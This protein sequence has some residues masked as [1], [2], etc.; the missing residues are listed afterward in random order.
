[1]C[2]TALPLLLQPLGCELIHSCAC[3]N[4]QSFIL[5]NPPA[6]TVSDSATFSPPRSNYSRSS[7]APSLL[8]CSFFFPSLSFSGAKLQ[9]ED[10]KCA[11]SLTLFDRPQGVNQ[12]GWPKEDLVLFSFFSRYLGSRSYFEDPEYMKQ[13]RS[14]AII[15]SAAQLSLIKRADIHI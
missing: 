8:N 13:S 5:Y 4:S 12:T 1:M 6:Q 7:C 9:M 15:N 3:G 2:N 14:A 10:N 11:T